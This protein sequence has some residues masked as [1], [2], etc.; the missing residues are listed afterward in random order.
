LSF[1]IYRATEAQIETAYAIVQE[2][3]AAASVL[4]RENREEFRGQYFGAGA[5]VWLVEAD[6][7]VVGC[8]ALRRLTGVTQAG[9]IKRMYVRQPYRGLGIAD[10]LLEALEKY[11]AEC[12]YKWLY[13][14]TAAD[15]KAAA[16]FYARKGFQGC[17]SYNENPQ[18]ALFMRKE[19]TSPKC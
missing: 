15:M 17:E 14:D 18:A 5:G 19:I 1:L 6:R 12:G 11:A 13:L 10:L 16:R 8:V 7:E 4:V 2:Y 9:E 3:Y